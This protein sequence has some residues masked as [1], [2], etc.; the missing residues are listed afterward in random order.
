MA[1]RLLKIILPVRFGNEAKE[2]LIAREDLRY[3]QEE[4]KD[5]QIVSQ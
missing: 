3:W 1:E 4:G 5:E 2:M